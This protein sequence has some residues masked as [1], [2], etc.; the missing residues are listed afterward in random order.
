MTQIRIEQQARQQLSLTPKQQQSV[1]L[2]QMST[3]ELSHEVNTAIANNPFLEEPDETQ[4]DPEAKEQDTHTEMKAGTTQEHDMPDMPA[5][6]SGDYPRPH[7]TVEGANDVGVWARSVTSLQDSLLAD[8]CNYALSERDRRLAE[9]IIEAMDDNGYMRTPF[10]ELVVPGQF[11]PEVDNDEWEIALRLV[12]QL[13][14]PG[15]GARDLTECLRLQLE[16]LHTATPRRALALQIVTG[17][18]DKLGRNDTPGLAHSLRRTEQEIQAACTLIRGLEPYPGNRHSTVDPSCYIVPDV[19]VRKSNTQWVAASNRDAIPQAR[20]NATYARL[21]RGT[22][23]SERALM[24]KELQEARW[25]LRSLEQRGNTIQR[26]AQAIVARQQTF[27][28]YG[29]IALR[30]LMLSEVAAELDI[31]ESTVSRA[32]SNKYLASP[33]GIFEFKHF[34]SRE[35]PT[36][37]GGTCSAGAVRALI[38]EMIEDED[39]KSPLSDVVLAHKLEREGIVV[40]RRT[41]SKYRAQ[42]KIPSA[43]L[44]RAF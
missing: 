11:D 25:L 29:E 1:K 26:V 19:I 9:H 13:G 14:T 32:T 18:L 20:L 30:P 15:L 16:A 3:L 6:W 35:L 36:Q 23:Y 8:L 33:R 44:R 39:P 34:F 12:Q 5:A 10:S 28:E 2:L 40:A 31:H 21:F 7:N 43:E 27:F 37:S 41:V 4:T 22:R 17:H 38:Q 24:A 42:I